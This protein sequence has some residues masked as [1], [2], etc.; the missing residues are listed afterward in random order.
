MKSRRIFPSLTALLL[1]FC[2]VAN[3]QTESP[4]AIVLHAA[5]LLDIESGRILQ[6]GEVL[7]Q[8][9]RIV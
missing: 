7:V 4:H 2:L 9:E 8:G 3:A 1:V 5:R 6:P